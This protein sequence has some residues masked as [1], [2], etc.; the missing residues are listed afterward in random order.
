[1]LNL[2]D[3]YLWGRLKSIVYATAANDAVELQHRVED[4][5]EFNS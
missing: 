3:F 2:L 4:G 1:V 5:C